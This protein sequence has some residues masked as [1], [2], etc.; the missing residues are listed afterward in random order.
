MAPLPKQQA[1]VVT[2]YGGRT[3]L[4]DYT[5]PY[6]LKGRLHTKC[7]GT[8]AWTIASWEANPDHPL[9]T[10]DEIRQ[11]PKCEACHGG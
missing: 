11:L 5:L 1:E 4:A 3:H 7:R 6:E 10:L 2:R 8:S 9:L